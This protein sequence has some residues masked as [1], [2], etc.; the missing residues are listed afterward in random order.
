MV[1]CKSKGQS[2][3]GI[4]GSP[5]AAIERNMQDIFELDV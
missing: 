3:S 1:P 2:T 5:K 4:S